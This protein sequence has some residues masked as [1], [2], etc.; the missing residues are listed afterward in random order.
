MEEEKRNN[1]Q[2]QKEAT[3]NRHVNGL[4]K[5][6]IIPSAKK[7]QFTDALLQLSSGEIPL[8]ANAMQQIKG[9][10]PLN[11]RPRQVFIKGEFKNATK[12]KRGSMVRI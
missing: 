1:E 6:G 3:V 5:R 2:R 10:S 12:V 9:L 7:E 8:V 4:L 11:N